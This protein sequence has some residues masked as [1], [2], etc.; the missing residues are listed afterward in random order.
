MQFRMQLLQYWDKFLPCT[1]Q[2]KS[3]K[4]QSK[5]TGPKFL[6]FI[7]C[8]L[9]KNAIGKKNYQIHAASMLFLLNDL[10]V[11]LRQLKKLLCC[12]LQ[13][14]PSAETLQSHLAHVRAQPSCIAEHLFPHKSMRQILKLVKKNRFITFSP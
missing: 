3:I 13:Y 1:A 6:K 9:E 10:Q 8:L 14:G 11:T 2:L 5:R 4:L 12:A 7:V